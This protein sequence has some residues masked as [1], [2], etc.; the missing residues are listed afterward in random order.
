M[1]QF[2]KLHETSLCL[3][4]SRY[5]LNVSSSVMYKAYNLLSSLCTFWHCGDLVLIPSLLLCKW[6]FHIVLDA[7]YL[8]FLPNH[9]HWFSSPSSSV[10]CFCVLRL[11]GKLSQG[12]IQDVNL[13]EINITSMKVLQAK[14]RGRP[15]VF[16]RNR[17]VT[18][19]Y[20]LEKSLRTCESIGQPLQSQILRVLLKQSNYWNIRPWGWSHMRVC[21]FLHCEYSY[22]LQWDYWQWV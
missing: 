14:K 9:F 20:S 2:H 18:G 13:M 11:V 6:K 1:L 16:P 21:S 17:V 10:A 15:V 22:W 5:F 19:N 8:V 12:V 3:F 7:Q 4:P